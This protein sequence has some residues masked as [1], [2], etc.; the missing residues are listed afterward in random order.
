MLIGLGNLCAPELF[1][2]SFEIRWQRSMELSPFIDLQRFCFRLQL[3]FA[4][5]LV[6]KVAN[7]FDLLSRMCP[8]QES[9][10]NP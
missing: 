9:A 4:A 3:L 7:W 2:E 5:K 6:V 1:V 8:V 10:L